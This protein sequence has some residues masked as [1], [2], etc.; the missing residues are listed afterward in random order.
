[1]NNSIFRMLIAVLLLTS[2][3]VAQESTISDLRSE[4]AS[5]DDAI[6]QA[7]VEDAQ[8]VGGL[9]KTLIKLRLELLQTNRA[10]V[11]QRIHAVES[12]AKITIKLDGSTPNEDRAAQLTREMESLSERIQKTQ[13]EV[14]KYSGGLIKAQL[15]STSA[16]MEN[17]LAILELEYLKAKYGIY[18]MPSGTTTTDTPSRKPKILNK[19]SSTTEETKFQILVPTLSNKKYQKADYSYNIWFDIS[20]DT[21]NLPKD[22]RAVKGTLIFADLFGEA[23]LLIGKT[24]NDR[25][26]PGGTFTETGIGF[27]Y[28]QFR[29]NHVWVRST[30]LSDMTFKFE[31]KSIIYLDGSTE[32]FD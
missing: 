7:N 13:D 5:I 14:S 15:M 12:G 18:W 21:K 23:K 31:V 10:L 16:T 32:T 3:V 17:T 9:I 19:D 8:L 2:S 30:D 29:D 1:M 26:T 4:L 28:N 20:W 24:I 27:E 25:L 11:Q 6:S 22:T